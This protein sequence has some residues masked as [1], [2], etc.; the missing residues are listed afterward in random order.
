MSNHHKRLGDVAAVFNGKTPSKAEQRESGF[1]VLKIKDVSD[2]GEFRGK[3]TSFIEPS[4]A[5]KHSARWV[6]GG[7][8]LILNAAHNAGYVASKMFLAS[9]DVAGVLP[10]GEWLLVRPDQTKALPEYVHYWT[11]S[12]ETR[13]SIRFI[14]KGIH[15]Y[16]KDVAEL[17][18]PLPPLAE[19]RRLVDL[20]TRAEG[21][22]RLRREAQ[23]KAAEIIPAL[24]LDIF[25]DPATNPKGWNKEP[26][27]HACQSA[28]D[29]KCGPFGTQ[30]ARSEF[31]HEGIPLWGIKHVNLGF[32]IPTVEFVTAE[33]AAELSSYSII[34]GDI[35][36]TRNGTI[37]NCAMYREGMPAGVM[38]SDLLRIRPDPRK[39]QPQFRS[40]EH[41][42]EL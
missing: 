26:I 6:K 20:L 16:P 8:S 22:V 5:E 32:A 1:P 40:E 35:V 33:K 28:D 15:L 41:T 21:I 17:R 24:F 18:I 4:L 12:E 25:G 27:S 38:H 39:C 31:H 3:F 19:Q 37:G 42:S 34:P 14:V 23:K 36:M 7:D 10:T 2:S 9:G 29:I 30:L 11:R 13:E